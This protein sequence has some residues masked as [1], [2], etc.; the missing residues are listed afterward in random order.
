MIK[1]QKKLNQLKCFVVRSRAWISFRYYRTVFA[2]GN[3]CGRLESFRELSA[4]WLGSCDRISTGEVSLV[5][6]DKRTTKVDGTTTETG[7]PSCVAGSRFQVHSNQHDL[8]CVPIIKKSTITTNGEGNRPY[9]ANRSEAIARR[10]NKDHIKSAPKQ[11]KTAVA[12]N[13][14]SRTRT[15][16]DSTTPPVE[17]NSSSRH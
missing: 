8:K 16:M 13:R 5:S 2:L 11:T 14:D 7:R 4:Y 6:S 9:K 10:S 15:Q 17:S 12:T 1:G 3:E